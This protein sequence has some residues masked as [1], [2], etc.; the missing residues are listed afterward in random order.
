MINNELLE[1]FIR[2]LKVIA[3]PAQVRAVENGASAK[4]MWQEFIESG[5]LDALV[6]D[7]KGGA[8]LSLMDV[9][10]LIEALGAYTVPLPVAETMVARALLSDA[11]VAVPE[12]PIAFA[13]AATAGHIVPFGLVAEHIL[14][15]AGTMLALV[16]AHA[17]SFVSTGVYGSLSARISCPQMLSDVPENSTCSRPESGL[18]PLAAILRT[19]QIAGVA[20][21]LLDRTAD[22]ANE[23]KQFGKPIARQQ[24]LQQNMAVMAE[25]VVA[26]R[27]AAQMGSQEGLAPSVVLA[28]IV[29]S[30]ASTAAARMAATAHAVHGAIGISEEYD[31]QLLVRRIHESRLAD[32]S[33]GYWNRL[34][35][36]AR[37]D[38]TGRSLDWV[39]SV[40][41]AAS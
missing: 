33:T 1:P 40:A 37:L 28:A 41:F 19:A 31:L 21:R 25:D 26:V 27:L 24:V 36:E 29:K 7:E 12:G 9:V 20:G 39:R 11:G 22:Y 3:D 4:P 2:M 38:K 32:G 17:D 13:T 34:L 16:P 14:M 6:K 10:P 18:R 30:V 5:F 8:G 35:G 15:D 23:R